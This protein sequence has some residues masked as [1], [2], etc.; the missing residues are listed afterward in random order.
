M[1]PLRVLLVLAVLAG[2]RAECRDPADVSKE[3]LN[4]K[5]CCCG[6]AASLKA[7]SGCCS[8]RVG[9][10]GECCSEDNPAATTRMLPTMPGDEEKEDPKEDPKEEDMDDM[11]YTTTTMEEPEMM[12]TTTGMESDDMVYMTGAEA[13]PEPHCMPCTGGRRMLFG[14]QPLPCC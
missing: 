11:M 12:P 9:D 13:E 8:G 2:A 10:Q 1:Q 6:P 3:D 7:G 14:S 4:T 5:Y